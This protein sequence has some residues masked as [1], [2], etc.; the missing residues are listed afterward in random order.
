MAVHSPTSP[1]EVVAA[2]FAAGALAQGDYRCADCGYG[3]TATRELPV[4][5]MCRGETWREQ[6]WSPFAGR[7]RG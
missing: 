3:I 5:P 6:R 4:C 2:T 7:P 1:T